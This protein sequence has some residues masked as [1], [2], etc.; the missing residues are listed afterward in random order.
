MTQEM[1]RREFES[2]IIKRANEDETFRKMLLQDPKQAIMHEFDEQ[3][4]SSIEIYVHDEKDDTY[5]FVIP[6]N[7]FSNSDDAEL[8]DDQ[9]EEI[10][11]GTFDC[12]GIILSTAMCTLNNKGT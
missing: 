9:L 11:G 5:H 2:R 6:W 4:P 8:S 10:A 12:T 3:I 7:P 1:T